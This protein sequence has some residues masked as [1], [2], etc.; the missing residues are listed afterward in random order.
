MASFSVWQDTHAKAAEKRR[1]A[2]L[3]S[4]M[5]VP[6]YFKGEGFIVAMAVLISLYT[7]WMLK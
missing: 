4:F 2:Y 6:P 3:L 5:M 1:S 7:F